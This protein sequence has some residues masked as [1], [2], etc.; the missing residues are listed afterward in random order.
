MVSYYFLLLDTAPNRHINPTMPL[1]E[2]QKASF[3]GSISKPVLP[4]INKPAQVKASTDPI[5]Y[6]ILCF[7]S[8]NIEWLI[9]LIQFL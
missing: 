6:K 8:I 2:K 7:I 9:K 4:V 5:A 3:K 1:I